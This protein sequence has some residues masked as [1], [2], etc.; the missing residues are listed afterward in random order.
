VDSLEEGTVSFQIK[1]QGNAKG[2]WA[3]KIL[4]RVND[5]AYKVNVP[6]DYGVSTTFNVII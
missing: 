4:K 1:F 5:N 6:E 2:R 3:F